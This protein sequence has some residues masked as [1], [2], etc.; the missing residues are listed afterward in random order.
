MLRDPT[1]GW[2]VT[3]CREIEEIVQAWSS[4]AGSPGVCAVLHIGFQRPPARLF[5]PLVDQYPG[6]V[7]ITESTKYSLPKE[8]IPSKRSIGIVDGIPVSRCLAGWGYEVE[9]VIEESPPVSTDWISEDWIFSFVSLHPE[10]KD[11]IIACGITSDEAYLVNEN[12]LPTSLRTTIGYFRFLCLSGGAT[13]PIQNIKLLP[14]WLT[15]MAIDDLDVPVRVRNALRFASVAC[16]LDLDRWSVE[17]LRSIPNFGKKCV[18]DLRSALQSALQRGV[19]SDSTRMEEAQKTDLLTSI[20]RSITQFSER[21]KD[22]LRRRM[23]LSGL[24]SGPETLQQI[25]DDYDVTRER[26]RQLESKALRRLIEEELWDDLFTMKV[27]TLVAGR[28]F[29]LPLRGIEALDP[30]FKGVAEH[31]EAIEYV[32]RNVCTSGVALVEIDCAQYLSFFSQER[33]ESTL[34]EARRLLAASAKHKWSKARCE[35]LV[36]GLLPAEASEFRNLLWDL[37]SKYCHFAASPDGELLLTSV[38]RGADQLVELVLLESPIPLH[39][40]EIAAQASARSSRPID[41]RRAHNAA[42]SVG[43]LLGRGIYGAERHLPI[44]RSKLELLSEEAESIVMSSD[45]ARQWHTGELL[46]ELVDRGSV[47]ASLV[48][49]YVLDYALQEFSELSHLKRMVWTRDTDSQSQAPRIDVHQAILAVVERSDRPLRTSEVRL[50][51]IALR[52]TGSHF[53][54][55]AR[56]PLIRVGTALWGLNDRDLPVKRADQEAMLD[57]LAKELEGRGAGI[58]VSEIGHIEHE[59][60][61]VC[62]AEAIFCLASEDSRFKISHSQYVYLSA[63]GEPRRASV[64]E[65]VNHV[66]SSALAPLSLNEIHTRVTA[67]VG[68]PIERVTISGCLQQVGAVLDDSGLWESAPISEYGEDDPEL[69]DDQEHDGD[70]DLGVTV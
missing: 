4:K 13:D 3:V 21:E 25:A 29:P 69:E 36:H 53:Q 54:I 46:S 66:L 57:A 43:I 45:V 55:Y 48:S 26:I 11:P 50:R 24:A 17:D 60:L 1:E 32:L 8:F 10:A 40:T 31:P 61:N 49:P 12:L 67:T 58:H 39:F 56:D 6:E 5:D 65:A 68:R 20:H 16:V 18:D 62:P 63:W 34:R 9:E 22:V 23:G 2:T 70:V 37:A 51:L 27:R 14:P 33:W 19:L 30:W 38:G 47:E 28:E 64:M 44:D 41:A 35:A 42:R 59:L 15:S 7:L 52:G